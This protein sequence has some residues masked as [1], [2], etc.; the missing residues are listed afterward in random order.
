MAW[1][2]YLLKYLDGLNVPVEVK[3]VLLILILVIFALLKML[4]TSHQK[5]EELSI[6]L[7]RSIEKDSAER[8]LLAGRQL[9]MQTEMFRKVLES[10]GYAP[11][12]N[13]EDLATNLIDDF[14]ITTKDL[15]DDENPNE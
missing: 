9:T 8:S 6:Y 2:D 10:L 1:W 5:R 12:P 3:L 13:L 14:E 15:I 11:T 4:N 7:I